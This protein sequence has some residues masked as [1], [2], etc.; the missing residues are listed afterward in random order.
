[1]FLSG[2]GKRAALDGARSDVRTVR[3]RLQGF[4]F[5]HHMW[6]RLPPKPGQVLDLRLDYLLC[7]R[8][9]S[10]GGSRRF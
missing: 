4:A 6:S 9:A 8:Q 2:N 3:T 1:M 10:A 7:Q 5:V